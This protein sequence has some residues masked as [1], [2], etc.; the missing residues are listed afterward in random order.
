M[1][2]VIAMDTPEIRTVLGWA[3]LFGAIV[4]AYVV[5]TFVAMRRQIRRLQQTNGDLQ[6]VARSEKEKIVALREVSERARWFQWWL[7]NAAECT[8]LDT[9]RG[10]LIRFAL[11]A[12]L[13]PDLATF[14][15]DMHRIQNGA[16]T[17]QTTAL[18]AR[19]FTDELN[20]ATPP[21][22]HLP[23][24][25]SRAPI[26]EA[27]R[28]LLAGWGPFLHPSNSPAAQHAKQKDQ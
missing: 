7:F 2:L 16:D 19:A 1:V 9:G 13:A 5:V 26:D 4:F 23:R 12:Q 15:R 21:W 11:A 25:S 24:R 27:Y 14:E 20:A 17:P 28:A 8:P 22:L 3:G 6:T 18:V 10:D